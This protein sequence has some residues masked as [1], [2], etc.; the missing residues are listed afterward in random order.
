MDASGEEATTQRIG[1]C[2]PLTWANSSPGR[3]LANRQPRCPS[4]EREE[5]VEALET[6]TP[7][8]GGAGELATATAS[9]QEVAEAA[10]E[11]T[12][13]PPAHLEEREEEEAEVAPQADHLGM[14]R[15]HRQDRPQGMATRTHLGVPIS[16]KA[17]RSVAVE[18]TLPPRTQPAT[19]PRTPAARTP[20]P[21]FSRTTVARWR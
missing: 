2:Q 12:L 15:R 21:S 17:T 8:E 9:H 5:G 20:S 1:R 6:P 18:R 10:D 14:A 7:Q 13:L 16:N 4:P 3:P 19:A 11:T